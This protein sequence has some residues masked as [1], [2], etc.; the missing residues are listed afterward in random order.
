MH[1]CYII[2]ICLKVVDVCM[3]ADP[4]LARSLRTKWGL[5]ASKQVCVVGGSKQ[6]SI[7][8][9][10]SASLGEVVFEII[11]ECVGLCF[12]L[13]NQINSCCC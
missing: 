2:S 1:C 13:I 8:F 9:G 11:N 7:F 12:I 3:Y 10:K 5:I 6:Q 4:G